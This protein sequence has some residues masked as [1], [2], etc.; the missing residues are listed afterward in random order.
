MGRNRILI[1]CDGV[2]SDFNHSCVNLINDKLG[3]NHTTDDI[4]T[5]DTFKHFG[6]KEQEH[7]L[8]N[9]I[10]N[11]NFCKNMP[12]LPGAKQAVERLRRDYGDV[13][14][15]TAHHKAQMWVFERTHWL[16]HHFGITRS[17]LVY[18]HAKEVV[19]GDVLIEDSAKNLTKWTREFDKGI[20]ILWDRSYNQHSDV[21][22]IP[23]LT[24]V[25]SWNDVF[26][27]L[28]RLL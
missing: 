6:V 11:E 18:T 20:P 3:L 22:E 27:T 14:V 16:E 7:I 2:L 5:W 1:D 9:A 17:H 15:V 12:V 21:S 13:Y 24:R 4:K 10:N 23:N 25:S 26:E 28:D 8:D 19:K